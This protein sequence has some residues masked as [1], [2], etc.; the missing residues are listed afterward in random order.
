LVWLLAAC[1]DLPQPFLGRPGATAMRLA[2]PPPSRL[3]IPP[4]TQSLLTEGAAQTWSQALADALVAQELPVTAAA[5][6][7]GDWHL[8]LTAEMQDGAV[9][10][11][12]TVTDPQGV[13]QGAS[14]GPPVPPGDWA[15]GEPATLK[16][17]ADAEAPK[18]VA[19]LN[20]IE[21]R[22]QMS[23][24]HS[25]LNRPPVIYF[26]GVT[27]AP[28]DG[29]V[30]LTRLMTSRLPNQG[31]VV[32][33]TPKGADYTLAGVIKTAPGAGATLRVEI[34]WIVDDAAGQE[35]GRVVQINEVPLHSLDS[36]WGEVALAVANEAAGGVQEVL[37]QASGRATMPT[38]AAALGP[39]PPANKPTKPG[40]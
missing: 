16:A 26:K 35:R 5:A 27:G 13:P 24:P 31:D 11:T 10:P 12:Y 20:G 29:N 3:A 6:H 15:A 32:Q 9:V 22:R 21:A 37:L 4:P 14:Q 25:L 8:L 23:D 7:P 17:A 33:D 28:G 18:V 30:S 38:A 36:Y 1:G 39:Q 40:P 2:Q 34:Q 19:L